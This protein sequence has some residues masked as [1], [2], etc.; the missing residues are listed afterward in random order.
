M[1]P[2]CRDNWVVPR[3]W[4]GSTVG[5]QEDDDFDD[6]DDIDDDNDDALAMTRMMITII[7]HLDDAIMQ[8]LS[9]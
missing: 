1:R 6:D 5:C 7:F 4:S 9:L 3:F 8:N 2:E